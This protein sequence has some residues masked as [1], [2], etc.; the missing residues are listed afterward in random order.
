MEAIK[1]PVALF[2]DD[3]ER[4]LLIWDLGL[5]EISQPAYKL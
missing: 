2:D 3:D 4:N 1:R 5:P